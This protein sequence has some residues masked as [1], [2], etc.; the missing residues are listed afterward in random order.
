MTPY[1]CLLELIIT[2]EWLRLGDLDVSAV[3]RKGLIQFYDS[4]RLND[5]WMNF[6]HNIVSDTPERL[7]E[8]L[9]ADGKPR[10]EPKLRE[11]VL[12][13]VKMDRVEYLDIDLVVNIML[14]SHPIYVANLINELHLV[15]HPFTPW[16][17]YND[18]ITATTPSEEGCRD[19]YGKMCP[20]RWYGK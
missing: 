4:A 6:K 14:W 1:N 10:V 11:P 2:K 8:Y 7:L 15:F 17:K 18:L 3:A 20:E 13:Q 12:Q 9:L 16:D 19:R 5:L